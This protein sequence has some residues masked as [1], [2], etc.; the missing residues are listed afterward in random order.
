MDAV[1][2]GLQHPAQGRAADAAQ[3]AL[4]TVLGAR[5]SRAVVHLHAVRA[6]PAGAH[7][8]PLAAGNGL[9]VHLRRLPGPHLRHALRAVAVRFHP[10]HTAILATDY[11]DRR[12]HRRRFAGRLLA[13]QPAAQL[14]VRHWLRPQIRINI[15]SF[16]HTF[17][18]FTNNR[19]TDKRI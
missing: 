7:P 14:E 10:D 5:H 16:R 4:H 12:A 11:D 3:P 6:V 15:V 9:A 1:L 2:Y 19:L 13:H 17:P 8:E 18:T